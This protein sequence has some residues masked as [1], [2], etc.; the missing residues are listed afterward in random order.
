MKE[1][2]CVSLVVLKFGGTS[3]GN[4]EKIRSVADKIIEEKRK[5]NQ[6]IIVVSA[7]GKTTDQLVALADE[8]TDNPNKREMDMLLSTGEQVT[9]SLLSMALREKG[10]EAVSFTGWQAGIIT[11]Q[12]HSNARIT[13]VES[14]KIEKKLREGKIVIVAGFQGM[15]TEGEITTLGRGGSDTS[16]VALA[17]ALQAEKCVICTDVPGIFTSDPRYIKEARKLPS[18]SY[19]EMLELANLGASVLHPRSVELAKNHQIPI[20]VC[21][22]TEE[23][24]GTRIEE[25]ISMEKNLIV[26]GVAFEE[27][28]TRVTIFWDDKKM[29]SLDTI[30][31][32][33]AAHYLNVDIIVQSLTEQ[34]KANFSFSIK[35][36]DLQEVLHVLEKNKNELGYQKIEYESGLAKVSIVGSGMISNPGIAAKMFSVLATN[37]MQI[38]MVST[39]EIKVSVVIDKENMIEATEA[40][41]RAFGLHQL[42]AEKALLHTQA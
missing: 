9:I 33:L 26:R 41:H 12:L 11:E 15:T 17:A 6:L 3:V 2:E 34:N 10:H 30:F 24:A 14:E 38:K 39:S 25:E 21:S 8:V 13:G 42:K 22:S 19:D 40:L 23:Q 32:T 7:M 35:T 37:N 36:E 27:D 31:T 18:I 28:I 4:V 20:E 16:A 29:M 1:D 5:G